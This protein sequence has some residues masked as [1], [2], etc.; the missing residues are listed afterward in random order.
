MMYIYI[1]VKQRPA[2]NR[3]HLQLCQTSSKNKTQKLKVKNIN[4]LEKEIEKY[5]NYQKID[6]TPLT[7]RHK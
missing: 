4:K 6:K 1:G 7:L 5:K 2:G 3:G